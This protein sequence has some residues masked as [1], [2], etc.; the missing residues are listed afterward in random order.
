LILPLH[1]LTEIPYPVPEKSYLPWVQAPIE[2]FIA[3]PPLAAVWALVIK[4]VDLRCIFLR[5][6]HSDRY[7]YSH[8][9]N[10]SGFYLSA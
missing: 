5:G 2:V 10:L 1:P 8:N 6:T 3:F 9:W 7:F 4:Y